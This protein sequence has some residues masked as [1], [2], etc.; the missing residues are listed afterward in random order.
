MAVLKFKKVAQNVLYFLLYGVVFTGIT[1]LASLLPG[2]QGHTHVPPVVLADHSG[3]GGPRDGAA[4][5]G[6][7]GSDSSDSG[8]GSP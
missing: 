2:G 3:D 8:S 7:D 4:D 1:Y 6:A 5:A